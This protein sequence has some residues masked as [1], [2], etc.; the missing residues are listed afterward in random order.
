MSRKILTVRNNLTNE[1]LA[2]EEEL[3]GLINSTEPLADVTNNIVVVLKKI[4]AIDKAGEV[5]E[6]Y[7]P[8]NND[9][10]KTNE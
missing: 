8:T 3:E 7:L 6:S 4:A 5:W 10:T 1:R 2:L 9:L